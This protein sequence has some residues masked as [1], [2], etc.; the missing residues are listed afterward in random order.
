MTERDF[1][2]DGRK[3]KLNKL[4]PFKQAHILRRL[5]PIMAELMPLAN[6]LANNPNADQWEGLVPIIQGLSKLSDQDFDRVFIGLLQA[7]EMQQTHGNW[8]RIVSDSQ[9]NFQDLELPLL[10]KLS[11]R[12]FG[13]NLKGFLAKSP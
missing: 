12:A 9:L 1:E 11:G 13:Y 10:L 5:S 6:R 2:I 4:D 7:V 8:A 3:F